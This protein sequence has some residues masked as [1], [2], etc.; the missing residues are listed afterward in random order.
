MATKKTSIVEKMKDAITGV[1]S[2]KPDRAPAKPA[3]AKAP[4][5]KTAAKT[6]AAKKTP[7]KKAAKSGA[8][9]GRL[10]R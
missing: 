1:F 10:R 4:A 3:T 6:T 5:K 9:T 2:S 8:K 7:A